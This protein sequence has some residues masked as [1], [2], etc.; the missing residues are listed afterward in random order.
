MDLEPY[1]IIAITELAA[2]VPL[3]AGVAPDGHWSGTFSL[4]VTDSQ[5]AQQW[6]DDMESRVPAA[7]ALLRLLRLLQSCFSFSSAAIY[8]LA[9][10]NEWND[11]ITRLEE[12]EVEARGKVLQL[13]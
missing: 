11:D 8:V 3:M 9:I 13:N 12:D 2:Y 5:V 1:I 4:L 10:N 6:I 7:K